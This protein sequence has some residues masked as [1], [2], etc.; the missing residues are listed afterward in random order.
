[1]NESNNTSLVHVKFITRIAAVAVNPP[2]I[3]ADDGYWLFQQG[4]NFGHW[5]VCLN[6]FAR[7]H[8]RL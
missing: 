5:T 7:W 2:I 4:K 3:M 1:M 6:L 8:Q